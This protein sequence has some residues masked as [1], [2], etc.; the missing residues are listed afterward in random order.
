MTDL[1][2]LVVAA[3]VFADEYP[4]PPRGGRR[5]LISDA[6]LIALQLRKPRSGSAPTGSSSA[7]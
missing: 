5:A 7:W 3:Y 4:V 2:V 1:E 6:E